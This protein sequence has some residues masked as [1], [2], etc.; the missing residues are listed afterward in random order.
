MELEQ[1]ISMAIPLFAFF[2]YTGLM[3]LSIKSSQ[4]KVTRLFQNYLLLMMDWSLG[5]FMMRTGYAPA[6]LFWNR[7]MVVGMTGVPFIF[8]RFSEALLSRAQSLTSKIGYFLYG[9]LLIANFKGLLVQDVIL[10]AGDLSYTIGPLAVPFALIS[11]GYVLLATILLVGEGFK[12]PA[13]FWSNR[14][15]YPSIGTVLMFIGC[16]L[17]L[18][19][20]IGKYPFDI[21]T[22]TI[23]AFLLTYAIYRYQ[24]LNITISIRKGLVYSFLTAMLTGSYLLLVYLL[25]TVIRNNLGYTA[26]IIALIMAAI[27]AIIFEPVKNWLR[28]RIDK[29]MFGEI[30]DYRKTL[31]Q[32]SYLKASILD[33]DELTHSTLG[34]LTKA[35]Q[36]NSLALLLLDQES[37]FFVYASVNMDETVAKTVRIDKTSPIIRRLAQHN[38]ILTWQEIETAPEFQGLWQL[39]KDFFIA[40]QISHFVGIKLGGELIGILVLPHK[41]SRDPYTDDDREMLLMLA[42]EAAVAIQ[43]AQIYSEV[44][45]QAV[46]DELTKLY[47]YRFFQEFMDKEIAR[48]QRTKQVFSVIYLDLDFFKAY[49]D[50]FGHL[51][52]DEALVTVGRAISESIRPSDIATRMG[53]DEFGIILPGATSHNAL[54]VAKRIKNA[55]QAYFPGTSKDSVLTIS[56]GIATYPQHSQNKQQLLSC[57]DT[58][59]YEAKNMGRNRVCLY[60]PQLVRSDGTTASSTTAEIERNFLIQQVEDAYLSVIY[61]LA[62]AINAKDNY[63]YQ[64]SEA[65]TYYSIAMAVILGFAEEQKKILRY[66]A[67]LHD[68]GKIG[69][70]GYI[71]NKPTALTREEREVIESHVLVA[72]GIV[73]HTPYL[74]EVAPIILHHHESYD[75]TGYPHGLIGEEIPIEARILTIADAYHAMISDRP[76]RQG[77]LPDVAL[78]QMDKLS[79]RQFDPKLLPIFASI[80]R[81]Q[82]KRRAAGEAYA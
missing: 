41:F 81:E 4:T 67:M 72:E 55:V 31:K 29:V 38:P 28:V 80:I 36:V 60:Q 37:N 3:I 22:N 27:I 16:T 46:R 35:L 32:F 48:C 30:Y 59:L 1:T 12:N 18:F 39:E 44:K 53:G 20:E 79:G 64:H 68:I 42:N 9:L 52:G 69:I 19:P 56:Q 66:A 65:V 73:S 62:A 50:I 47:N 76:Y 8:Y 21:L 82:Q 49:N 25:E 17:N 71:L 11:G 13:S 24:L 54:G 78:Q 57:A 77:M 2:L 70:P 7:M 45:R 6:P 5:S 15:L 33:L 10:S 23:N 40:M 63:T 58:A 61:T 34:L 75:G 43:N 14:L 74:R 51:A 26:F